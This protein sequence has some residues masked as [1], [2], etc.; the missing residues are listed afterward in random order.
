MDSNNIS[1][2]DNYYNIYLWCHLFIYFFF[3]NPHIVTFNS[4]NVILDSKN[5]SMR[6]ITSHLLVTLYILVL[7]KFLIL[8]ISMRTTIA[9]S[10]YVILKILYS[11]LTLNIGIL[12]QQQQN[13]SFKILESDMNSQ[14]IN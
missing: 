1:Y 6:V 7:F 4:I 2:D 11:S 9:S 12:S 8:V 3:F 5:I 10:L 14:K 13:L